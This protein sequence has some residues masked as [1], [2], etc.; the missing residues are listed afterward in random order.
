MSRDETHD[1]AT[2][3]RFGYGSIDLSHET[4]RVITLLTQL[5]HK[6][7]LKFSAR[8]TVEFNW[9]ENCME[10]TV[11]ELRAPTFY[12]MNE[13]KFWQQVQ[14]LRRNLSHDGT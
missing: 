6:I 2:D 10:V 4:F 8:R 5:F 13:T 3:H 14:Q 12:F 1:R 9:E 11:G 7:C